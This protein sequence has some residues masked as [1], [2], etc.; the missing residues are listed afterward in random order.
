MIVIIGIFV[1][2]GAIGGLVMGW[3]CRR[4]NWPN[5]TLTCFAA[6]PLVLGGFEHTIPLPDDVT[7]IERKIIVAATPSQIW[8]QLLNTP[9]IQPHEVEQAWMYRIGVPLPIEGVTEL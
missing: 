6:L 2:F 9:D 1:F 7:T 5:S 8:Q 3:I 4:Q